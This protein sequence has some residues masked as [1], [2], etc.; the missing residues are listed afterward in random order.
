M[1]YV[2]LISWTSVKKQS[3]CSLPGEAIQE[4]TPAGEDSPSA[5]HYG[6]PPGDSGQR[7]VPA[8]PQ[9]CCRAQHAV[10]PPS[11]APALPAASKPQGGCVGR[12][13]Q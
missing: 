4:E 11:P 1:F 10:P 9:Q 2:I 13:P 8:V 5:A 6:G 12:N 3:V 7:F